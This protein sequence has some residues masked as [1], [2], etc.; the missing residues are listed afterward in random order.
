[1]NKKPYYFISFLLIILFFIIGVR[2]GKNVEK[3]NKIID[4][5]LSLTP[6]IKISPTLIPTNEYKSKKWGVK[7]YYPKNFE[8]KESTKSPEFFINEKYSSSSAKN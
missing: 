8:I 2:Y 3:T 7:I 5:L 1:M 6:S 4:Y